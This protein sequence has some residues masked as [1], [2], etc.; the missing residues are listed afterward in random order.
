MTQERGSDRPWG[1][2]RGK[3]HEALF[4]ASEDCTAASLSE[5]V[6]VQNQMAQASIL[7]KHVAQRL[8]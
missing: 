7:L 8:T 2:N 6:A 1:K 3:V 4:E 5:G